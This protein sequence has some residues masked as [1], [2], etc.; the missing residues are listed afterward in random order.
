M[1]CSDLESAKGTATPLLPLEVLV[2]PL[3]LRFRYHFD[4][5][6]ATNRIDKPEWFLAHITGL[7]T[8]YTDFLREIVQPILSESANPLNQR[9]AVNEFI[10]ALLPIV[11][12]K[13]KNLLPQILD[14]AQLLSHFIHEMIKFDAELREEFYYTPFGC[15]G[16]WKGMTHEVLVVENGF[17]DWLHVEK[18][19][20]SPSPACRRISNRGCS[21]TVSLPYHSCCPR[22]LGLGL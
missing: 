21:R 13:T 6:R 9:D 14:Q 1:E 2:K 12:R 18:E 3:A 19:C 4:G 15:D 5:D 22:R 8:T 17:A 7:V 11:M 16:P 20:K 10:T